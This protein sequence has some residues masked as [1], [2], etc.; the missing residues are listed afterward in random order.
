M[1]SSY[2]KIKRWKL[3]IEYSFSTFSELINYY[4]N[5]SILSFFL[6]LFSYCPGLTRIL[7][8]EKL[9]GLDKLKRKEESKKKAIPTGPVPGILR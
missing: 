7:L 5:I 8:N 2:K 4:I 9:K 6:F 3:A 1:A